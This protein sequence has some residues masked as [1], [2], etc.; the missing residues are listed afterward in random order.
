M[1][2]QKT[3]AYGTVIERGTVKSIG[4]EGYI[5]SSLD[6]DGIV[7]P[8]IGP[9]TDETYAVSDC[10]YFFLFPDGHGKIIGRV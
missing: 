5:V 3:P 2:R 9:T 6:R 4:A 7:T 8:E 10:V 1:E